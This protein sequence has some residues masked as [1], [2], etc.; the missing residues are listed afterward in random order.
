LNLY[1]GKSPA[2]V[3]QPG[4]GH[5]GEIDQAGIGGMHVV[6]DPDDDASL[7]TEIGY[8]CPA[9]HR[10]AITGSC[11]FLLGED[12]IRIGFPAFEF[13]VV[14]TGDPVLN[15]GDLPV[16]VEVN[17]V[18]LLSGSKRR[19]STGYGSVQDVFIHDK[20]GTLLNDLIGK[21]SLP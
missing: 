1:P 19:Q 18:T 3:T 12:L 16:F 5:F 2:G 15:F 9:M 13:V 17:A 7:I 10:E 8:P 21:I 4:G 6:I 11:H 14:I 20:G